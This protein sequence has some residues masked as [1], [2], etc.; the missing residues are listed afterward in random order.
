MNNPNPRVTIHD[1]AEFDQ[2]LLQ[3]KLRLLQ[4]HHDSKVGHIGSNLS[5]LDALL[6]VHMH[7]MQ[8]ND[9]CIL[10]KGHAAGALYITL[11]SLGKIS[12]EQL[13]QFH[14]DGSKMAG[15][16]ISGWHAD[17]PISTGS[18]G[19][20][21]AVAAGIALGKKLKNEP[22]VVY[23][24]MSDGEWQEGSNW[25]ALIFSNHHQL[26]NL[27]LLIDGNKI[28]GFGST[29]EVASLEPLHKKIAAFG[30][31]TYEI[32][33]HDAQAL[34]MALNKPTT[35]KP[36]ALVLRTTK[37]NGISFMENKMEWHYLPLSTQ[38]YQQAV[39]EV[40]SV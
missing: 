39:V 35:L 40:Q 16:P 14:Q 7:A 9:V 24:F 8:P 2:K 23:C 21:L 5:I 19:H 25:E 31:Q 36:L 12:E 10:S 6:F 37:G 28:Q 17:I 30:I 3:A 32:A 38:Q 11:W 20:G 13:Q 27:I 34:T 33:G 26:D 18:L 1:F 15:H 29:D 22:G 4:M